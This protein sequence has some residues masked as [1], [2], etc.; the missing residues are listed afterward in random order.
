MIAVM[1]TMLAG[2]GI[3][4]QKGEFKLQANEQPLVTED[5]A[6]RVYALYEKMSQPERIAQ[7]HGMNVADLF[8]DGRL[9]TLKCRQLI[10]NGVGHF[11]QYA[12]Q[13]NKSADEVR[14]MIA[15]AQEWLIGN[16]P[17][18]IPA[19]CHEEVLT[20]IATKG[21]TIYPQQIGLAG[22]FNPE[23]AEVKT[24]QTAAQLRKIG[25]QLALSPMVDVCRNPHFNRLEESYGEDGYLSAAMGVGFV[26]GLQSEGL[27]DGVAACSKHFLGYGGG[28][29]SGEKELME[30]ILLPHEAM[31]R[32]AGSK[33]VMTGYH[34]FHG[35]NAVANQEL[36]QDILRTYIGFDGIMVSD[37]G[38]VNQLPD[39]DTPVGRAAAALNAGNDVEFQAGYNYAYLQQAIDSGLVS[40]EN[41]ETAVKRVL[42]LKARTGLL[43]EHP[44]LYAEG[45]IEFDSPEERQT[46]YE[47]A[48]QSVVMLEN[49]GA[50]PLKKGQKIFLTGPNAQ[51]MYA[52]LGDYTY[53][54]M[55][56]FWRHQEADDQHPRIVN[57]YD[58]LKNRLP[59]GFEL[60]YERGCDWTD[61]VE[62]VIAEGGDERA[63][64]HQQWQLGRKIDGKEEINRQKALEMAKESDIIIA[65][66]GENTMLCGENRDR[67]HL[68]LP[69]SQEQYV[70]ELIA[71]GR[72][73]VLVMFGGRA[74]VISKIADR[75][76]AIIQAWYPGEE[77]GNALADILY[78]NI[79]PSGK[80]S[81]SYPREEINENICYNYQ[82]EQDGRIQWPFGYGLS[83][84]SFEYGNLKADTKVATDARAIHL[85]FDLKNVGE[86]EGAEVVQLY[87]SPVEV[88]GDLQ[89]KEHRQSPALKPIQ[90]QGF[91]RVNLRAGEQQTVSFLISLQ[92]FG[93]YENG[94]WNIAPGRYQLKV[95]ASSQDIRLTADIELTGDKQEMKLRTVYFAE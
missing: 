92:Q 5:V 68:R 53:Q 69:G 46:A 37:Y 63:R 3:G 43:D 14:D 45:H 62:T 21:A 64:Q 29:E 81:V 40:Q 47:M 72:P 24:R 87:L 12:S 89:S 7:L 70:E 60:N 6:R 67:K 25:G 30:E 36:M 10:P 17:N 19:L 1:S 88:A 85:S 51:S 57:L 66:M 38:S 86:R 61:E 31:I 35:T 65:A 23:L 58:G 49:N 9:D 44:K 71:T 22:S 20:G 76:A 73:V 26:R 2:C 15:Q 55:S 50:L 93:Y 32:V 54:A 4:G 91:K 79:S 56:Y 95:A 39:I 28:S 48:T 18:K 34:Q 84:T 42:S 59:E 74:Q 13:E 27:H 77:G 80:L 75:L 94:H 11:C 82:T 90:L 8:T 83:Y 78:G 52:M 33:V 41:F 16:T